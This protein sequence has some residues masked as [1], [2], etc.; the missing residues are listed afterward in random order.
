MLQCTELSRTLALALALA[1]VLW[2]RLRLSLRHGAA[3]RGDRKCSGLTFLYICLFLQKLVGRF[4]LFFA[5]LE[6]G[7]CLYYMS[8]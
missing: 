5:I 8:I 4:L 3:V 1:P 7:I 2:L 6:D